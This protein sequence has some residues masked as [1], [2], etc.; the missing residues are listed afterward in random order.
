MM[1]ESQRKKR[2]KQKNVP[3][4]RSEEQRR[5]IDQAKLILMERNHMTES[6][7]HR[8]IQKTSMDSGTNIVETAQMVISLN[9]IE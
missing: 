3:V 2:K 7:A 6:E 5:L 9:H 1:C 4:E 8:Y